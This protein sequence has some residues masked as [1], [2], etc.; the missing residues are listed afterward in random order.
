[1]VLIAEAKVMDGLFCAVVESVE[2]TIVNSLFGAET[3]M[4]RD[5]HVAWALPIAEVSAVTNLATNSRK[6]ETP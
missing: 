4:G 2:E 6:R 1:M 5:D 3:M